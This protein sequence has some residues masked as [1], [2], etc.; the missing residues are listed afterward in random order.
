MVDAGAAFQAFGEASE[1]VEEGEGLFDD[2]AD[3]LVVVSG[4]AP[5]DQW[6]DS[7]LAQQDAVLFVVVTA[8]RD[9]HLRSSATCS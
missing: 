6:S 1:L 2:P 8:V 5:A 4:A 9:D 7:A 3:W